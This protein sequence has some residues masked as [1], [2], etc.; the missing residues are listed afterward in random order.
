MRQ[1]NP[2][3]ELQHQINVLEETFKKII[4]DYEGKLAGRHVPEPSEKPILFPLE[5][6]WDP[7][8][9]AD[10]NGTIRVF[11]A[12]FAHMLGDPFADLSGM[13][14]VDITPEKWRR[15]DAEI[16]EKQVLSRGSS[17]IYEKE[18]RRRDGSVFPVEL[19]LMLI[20]DQSDNPS[21]FWVVA[22]DITERRQIEKDRELLIVELQQA[23]KKVKQLSGLLPICATCGKMRNDEAYRR[24]ID[25][26]IRQNPE[27]SHNLRLCDAC[28]DRKYSN[29]EDT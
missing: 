13:N 20:K 2:F 19:K 18:Y 27:T 7:C 23:M 5:A 17:D 26:Y 21:G 25:A 28:H 24:Q 4:Q 8:A 10:L 14:L 15:L 1:D 3:E 9:R 22:R 16:L 29:S 12:P 6:I 11:N